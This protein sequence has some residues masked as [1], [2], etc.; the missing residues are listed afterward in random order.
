MCTDSHPTHGATIDTGE[1]IPVLPPVQRAIFVNANMAIAWL[2]P[3]H[4]SMADFSRND[5]DAPYWAHL[6]GS[7]IPLFLLSAA[8]SP[9]GARIVTASQDKTARVWDVRG[10]TMPAQD[11]VAESACAGCAAAPPSPATRCGSRAMPTTRRRS[12]CAPVSSECAGVE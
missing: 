12:T 2:R 4:K 10:A 3:N 11:L 9:D 8:F 5:V 7:E 6:A 1:I